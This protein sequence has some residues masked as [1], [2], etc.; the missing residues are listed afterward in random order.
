MENIEYDAMLAALAAQLKA[1]DA[2]LRSIEEANG[3]FSRTRDTWKVGELDSGDEGERAKLNI[4]EVFA[5]E[6]EN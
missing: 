1:A 5:V 2:D 6:I 3:I 4:L